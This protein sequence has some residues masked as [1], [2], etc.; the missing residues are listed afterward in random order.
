[1]SGGIASTASGDSSAVCGG[2]DNE[3]LGDR[4]TV[5]GGLTNVAAATA[6]RSRAA[7]SAR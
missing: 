2:S 3:A 1:M 4:S 6:H 5:G 7:W